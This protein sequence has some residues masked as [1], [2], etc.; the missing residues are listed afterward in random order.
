MES[1]IPVPVFP[2]SRGFAIP[3]STSQETPQTPSESQTSASP[4]PDSSSASAPAEAPVEAWF[5]EIEVGDLTE[6]DF[7]ILDKA[8]KA[9]FY[10]YTVEEFANMLINKAYNIFKLRGLPG[11]VCIILTSFEAY[12][13]H[14]FLMVHYLAGKKCKPHIPA[15]KAAVWEL[16]DRKNCDGVLYMAHNPN[17]VKY[18]GGKQL[19]TLYTMER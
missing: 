19:S 3:P 2:N 9:T 14:T 18:I 13:R 8:R 12:P 1:S 10:I 6:E 4:S 15:L 17:Y 16:A 11:T 5:E 7:P